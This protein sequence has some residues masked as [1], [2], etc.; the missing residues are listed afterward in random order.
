MTGLLVSQLEVDFACISACVPTVL[1]MS[2]EFWVIFC[3]RVLGRTMSWSGSNSVSKTG[4]Q[5]SIGAG[6]RIHLSDLHSVDRTPKP[7]GPYASFDKDDEGSMDSQEHIVKKTANA[8]G[9]IK[10]ETDYYVRVEEPPHSFYDDSR[11]KNRDGSAQPTY[12][13]TIVVSK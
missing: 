7:R 6:S 13:T 10:V 8:G 4:G 11:E 3:V 5:A 1:K 2:E 12:E 9:G